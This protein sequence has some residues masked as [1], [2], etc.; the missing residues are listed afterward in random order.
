ML[1]FI[2]SLS[3]SSPLSP[4]KDQMIA[5]L[6]T[7]LGDKHAPLTVVA[8]TTIFNVLELDHFLLEKEVCYLFC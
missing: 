8:I 6:L 4:Y 5:L 2:Y 3:V 7:A 1:F